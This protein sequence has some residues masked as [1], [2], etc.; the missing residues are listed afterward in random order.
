MQWVKS[1]TP[2]LRARVSQ[3]SRAMRRIIDNH[4]SHSQCVLYFRYAAF[5]RASTYPCRPRQIFLVGMT[6]GVGTLF[7]QRA[8]DADHDVIAL[9]RDAARVKIPANP[10]LKTVTGDITTIAPE[11]LAKALAGCDVVVTAYGMSRTGGAVTPN[12]QEKGVQALLAAMTASGV[13]RLVY[14]GACG[15]ARLPLSPRRARAMDVRPV[16]GGRAGSAVAPT[17]HAP[18]P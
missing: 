10:H 14:L 7:A 4:K 15:V 9:V 12:V 16:V 11:A 8:L 18:H 17:T 1:S 13:K 2:V 3:P 6:G 5:N